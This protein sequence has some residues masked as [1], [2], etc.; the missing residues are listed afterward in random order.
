[1]EMIQIYLFYMNS[2]FKLIIVFLYIFL[3]SCSNKIEAPNLVEISETIVVKK[4]NYDEQFGCT[5]Y[6][7]HSTDGKPV[8]QLLYFVYFENGNYIVRSEADSESCL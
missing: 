1:M 5:V 7:P 3:L 2:I 8:L 4:T 6:V